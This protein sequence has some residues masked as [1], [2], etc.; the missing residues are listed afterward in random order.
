M[1][2][3][4]V[5]EERAAEKYFHWGKELEVHQQVLVHREGKERGGQT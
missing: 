3:V 1:F 2:H 5:K 4:P